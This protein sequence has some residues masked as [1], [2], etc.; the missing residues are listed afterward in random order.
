M[1][2]TAPTPT[3]RDAIVQQIQQAAYKPREK[4]QVD[5]VLLYPTGSSMLNLCCSDR[6]DGG[7]K[8]GT[9]V[10]LP[11]SSAS[12]KTML[13]ITSL[14]C[15]IISNRFPKYTF[16][17]DDAETALDFDIAYL[18]GTQVNDQIYGP[19]HGNSETIQ[20]LQTNCLQLMKQDKPI[21]YVLDS[22]DSLSTD[23]E[24]EKEFRRAMAAAKSKE[25][26]DAIAGSYGTEKAKI[27]GQT[28]RMINNYLEKTNSLLIIIQQLRQ[29][30]NKM[31]FGNPYTTSGGEAPYF[32]SSHRVWLKKIGEIKSKSLAIGNTTKA[33]VEKNKTTG[34]HRSCEFSI[35][36]DY[37]VDDI[38]SMVDFCID[39]EIWKKDGRD[40]DAIDLGVKGDRPKTTGGVG[41]LVQQIEEKCLEGKLK[42]IVQEVWDE[43]E[44]SVLQNRKPRFE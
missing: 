28:L 20:K 18:F 37:G 39:Q 30:M 12:G 31:P 43:I 24:L 29:K 38:G 13:A 34:K 10:T 15:G 25:A 21:I 14:A 33:D 26:A 3:N 41:T 11:G 32:Y 27:L 35:Y 36:Q 16:I 42:S 1:G 7:F 2:R 22:L 19:P 4:R 9:I 40:Y 8:L 6:V 44:Q 17:Y 23:E 5:P